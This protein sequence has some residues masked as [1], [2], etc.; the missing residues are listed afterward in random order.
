MLVNSTLWKYTL[1]IP[2][3][4]EDNIKINIKEVRCDD[5]LWTKIGSG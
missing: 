3:R 5:A 1:G 4:L 2:G